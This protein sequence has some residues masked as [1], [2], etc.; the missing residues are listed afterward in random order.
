M[1]ADRY[2]GQD[3]VPAED[4]AGRWLEVDEISP[5]RFSGVEE[6]L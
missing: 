6:T 2:F 1:H 4:A 3:V 5:V